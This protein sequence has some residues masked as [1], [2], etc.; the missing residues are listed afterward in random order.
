MV[1]NQIVKVG[2]MWVTPETLNMHFPKS[3]VVDCDSVDISLT[4]SYPIVLKNVNG[5]KYDVYAK[6]RKDY[7]YILNK[8]K[9]KHLKGEEYAD[10]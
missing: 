4:E 10:Y 2:E 6:D 3:C 5:I 7:D 1:N 9:N 8:I